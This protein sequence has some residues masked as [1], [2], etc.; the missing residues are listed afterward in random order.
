LLSKF[1]ISY[2]FLIVF[3]SILLLIFTFDKQ[4]SANVEGGTLTS[5]NFSNLIVNKLDY[6]ATLLVSRSADPSFISQIIIPLRYYFGQ[7]ISLRP[8]DDLQDINR[9][10]IQIISDV[11]CEKTFSQQSIDFQILRLRGVGAKSF[12]SWVEENR[13]VF[14]CTKAF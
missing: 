6:E 4:I 8:N 3:L 13:R 10:K 1:R 7:K 12:G 9:K 5:N 11:E 2:S 14:I